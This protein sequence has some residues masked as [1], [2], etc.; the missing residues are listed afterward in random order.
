MP[1]DAL[2]R[3]GNKRQID[4]ARAMMFNQMV[5]LG[6]ALIA[7]TPPL[8]LT[9]ELEAA[10]KP[11]EAH[12]VQARVTKAEISAAG[13]ILEDQLESDIAWTLLRY[14]RWNVEEEQEPHEDGSGWRVDLVA[15]PQGDESQQ[16][17]ERQGFLGIGTL[18]SLYS[19]LF[20]EATLNEEGGVEQLA[21]EPVPA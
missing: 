12:V 18:S 4:L 15:R 20:N 14:G 16:M 2:E 11:T 17:A 19:A 9:L 5:R 21:H 1:E 8:T 6:D 3:R 10:G 13:V 7:T